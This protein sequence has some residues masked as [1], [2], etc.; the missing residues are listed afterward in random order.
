MIRYTSLTDNADDAVK[1]ANAFAGQAR[2][3]LRDQRSAT[4]AQQSARLSDQLDELQAD[5]EDLDGQLA[6][7]P[8]KDQGVIQAQRDAKVRQYGL[9]YEQYSSLSLAERA[10]GGLGLI[11]ATSA[12]PQSSEGLQP[13]RSRTSRLIIAGILELIAGILIVLIADRYDARIRTREGAEKAFELP[14]LA[15]VPFLPRR[16]RKAIA[17]VSQPRS[18]T[19]NAFRIATA[20]LSIPRKPKPRDG[21][22]ARPS[23]GNG[24]GN[25]ELPPIPGEEQRPEPPRTILMTSPGPDD[26]KTTVVANLAAAFAGRGDRTLVLSCDLRRPHLHRLLGAPNE[27]GLADVLRAKE[28]DRAD[29]IPVE[30]TS[31]ENVRLI[32]SGQ[33]PPDPGELLGSARMRSLLLAAR[34][35]ADVVLIDT[36]PI[37]TTSDAV[38]LV[39]QVDAVGSSPGRAP[40]RSRRPSGPSCCGGWRPRSSAW[41]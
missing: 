1:L 11:S 25:G 9:L 34:E 26:G 16:K 3:F 41:F 39:D 22:E 5:I 32:P 33:P 29:E 8:P 30:K 20:M 37:L 4:I 17:T 2:A 14:L 27:R 19:A 12:I 13:P 40:R 36:A 23:D 38:P 10:P 18:H 31:I 15:E 28:D 21:T 35:R 7:A 24:N 6:A